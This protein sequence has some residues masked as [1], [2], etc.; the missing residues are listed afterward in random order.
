MCREGNS[1]GAFMLHFTAFKNTPHRTH[2]RHF[3]RTKQERFYFIN[4]FLKIRVSELPQGADAFPDPI[5]TKKKS[6]SATVRGMV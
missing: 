4:Q 6:P 2:H 1:P 3:I 5:F